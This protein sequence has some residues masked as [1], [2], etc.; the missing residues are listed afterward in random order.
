[1]VL[2]WKERDKEKREANKGR[3]ADAVV[4]NQQNIDV[5]DSTV[6]DLIPELRKKAREKYLKEREGQQLNL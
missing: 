2:R 3:G 1:M 6:Q 4:D 5:N